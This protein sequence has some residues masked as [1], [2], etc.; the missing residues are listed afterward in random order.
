MRAR[1]GGGRELLRCILAGLLVLPWLIFAIPGSAA[2]AAVAATQVR[3]DPVAAD[4]HNISPVWRDVRRG[5]VGT[6]TIKGVETGVLVQT[7]GDAWRHLHNGPVIVAGGALLLVVAV[8]IAFFHHRK[9]SLRLSA[10]PTGRKLQRFSRFERV[11]HNTVAACF[12]LL[13]AGGLLLMFGKHVLIPLFGHLPVALLMQVMKPIHNFLGLLFALS[14]LPM[15]G[16]WV[17]DNVWASIDAQWIRRVGGLV[18]R[19]HVP[20]WRFNFGEKVWFWIGVTM[21]G[22]TVAASGVLLDFPAILAARGPLA[23][24]NLVHG[25]GALLMILLSL[26]HIYMGTIGVEGITELMQTG[27]IDEVWAKDHHELWYRQ[28]TGK[29]D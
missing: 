1:C 5:E 25:V 14:L 9:G 12:L 20:S 24:T 2:V 4:G 18:D 17:K 16:M 8:S 15:I 13:A 27:E 26:G 6:T 3:T 11:V 28:L 19:T 23:I 22:L 7:D 29:S 21:L 10:P